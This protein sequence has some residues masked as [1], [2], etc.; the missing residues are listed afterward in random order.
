LVVTQ[1]ADKYAGRGHT[2]RTPAYIQD[3]D[4]QRPYYG[5]ALVLFAH[6]SRP[7]DA[8]LPDLGGCA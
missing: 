5:R 3:A 6:V 2:C 8:S 4:K 7:S 1:D